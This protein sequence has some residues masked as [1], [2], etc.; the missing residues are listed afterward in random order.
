MDYTFLE[1]L[2]TK[3]LS[4]AQT[5]AARIEDAA[6]TGK[7]H[8]DLMA[9]RRKLQRAYTELGKEAHRALGEDAI[10]VFAR[11]PGVSELGIEIEGHK[12]EITALEARLAEGKSGRAGG[13]GKR[14]AS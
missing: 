3:V 1:R 14:S 11:R 4:G 13:E 6:R 2:K 12:R 7:L 10:A 5:S 9:A 8:L